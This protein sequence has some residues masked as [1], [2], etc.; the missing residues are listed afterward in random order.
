MGDEH[1][2]IV[3]ASSSTSE[4]NINKTKPFNDQLQGYYL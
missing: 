3:A 4:K 1:L 2:P